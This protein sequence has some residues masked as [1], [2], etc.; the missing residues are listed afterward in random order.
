MAYIQ[1]HLRQP[2]GVG[3][4]LIGCAVALAF[5]YRHDPVLLAVTLLPQIAAVAGYAVWA[6]DLEHYYYLSLM[7]AAIITT[8][9][10]A[11]ALVPVRFAHIA[12][13]VFLAGAIAIVP[14]RL[15]AAAALPRLPSYG[16]LVSA[17]RQIVRLKQ[18]MRTI[19]PQFAL[20]PSTDPTFIFRIL[21]GR[22]DRQA[23]WRAL[24]APDGRVT[25]SR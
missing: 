6:G 19:E 7:P 12:G 20:P 18:P 3:L 25:Y 22:I 21:G 11:A 1:L 14:S 16:V 24:V 17:S 10:A 8:L 4:I 9:L 15:R 5:Y 2:R 13:V 23:E